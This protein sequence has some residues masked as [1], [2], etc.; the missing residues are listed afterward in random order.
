[1]SFAAATAPDLPGTTWLA[2]EGDRIVLHTP[3]A[4]HLVR[5]LVRT[6]VD[7]TDLQVRPASLEEAFLALTD[8][9]AAVPAA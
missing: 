5:D 7:F 6:G 1:M 8:D 2:R 9:L 4:D 3:D